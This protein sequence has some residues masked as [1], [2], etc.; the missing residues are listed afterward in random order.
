MTPKNEKILNAHGVRKMDLVDA[1]Y[2]I[3]KECKLHK[4]TQQVDF[5]FLNG[6]TYKIDLRAL[7]FEP[8]SHI[9]KNGRWKKYNVRWR[10][11]QSPNIR[12]THIRRLTYDPNNKY[13]GLK[14]FLNNNTAIAPW[15]SHI[16][17]RF[18][19]NHSYFNP[20]LDDLVEEWFQEKRKYVTHVFP[21]VKPDD[22]FW[23]HFHTCSLAKDKK[24]ITIDMPATWE[25][26]GDTYHG[27]GD[28]YCLKLKDLL[29]NLKTLGLD[30][31]IQP[32]HKK[33]T[34]KRI[35]NSRKEKTLTIWLS[36]REKIV[37]T[38]HEVLSICD[39]RYDHYLG[40]Q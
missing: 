39:Y 15:C 19:P 27:G 30:N 33:L 2:G 24:S 40:I 12:A 32:N 11:D 6:I 23:G 20:A 29:D 16:H 35:K 7:L 31:D 37:L 25:F 13:S 1:P 34:I 5:V 9:Y 21:R 3:F 4:E 14:I 17:Y 22:A 36:N 18:E 38:P 28:K 26:F 10:S 8:I